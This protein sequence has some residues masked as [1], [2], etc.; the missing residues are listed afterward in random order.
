[1]IELLKFITQM[2]I[3]DFARLLL[4]ALIWLF[5]ILPVI[6]TIGTTVVKILIA[7]KTP[8]HTTQ[9]P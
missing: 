9:H 8:P 2:N 1:M 5:A 3:G 6:T 7:I 4:F